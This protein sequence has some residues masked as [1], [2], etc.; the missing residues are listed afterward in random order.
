MNIDTGGAHMTFTIT[1]KEFFLVIAAAAY[2]GG[3]AVYMHMGR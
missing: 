3:L 1:L 2:A